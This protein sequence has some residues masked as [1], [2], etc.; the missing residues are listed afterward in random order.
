[1]GDRIQPGARVDREL[2]EEFKRWVKKSRG[3]R[4]GTVGQELEKAMRDRINGSG[5]ARQE[6]RLDRIEQKVE[7]VIESTTA[8]ADGGPTPARSDEP[9]THTETD[10][11][12]GAADDAP[13]EP[14]HPKASRAVKADYLAARLDDSNEVH[15]A[16]VLELVD[17]TYSFGDEATERLVAATFDRL[18]EDRKPHPRVDDLLIPPE[19]ADRFAE[20]IREDQS[21][22]ADARLDEL[23][24]ADPADTD[25]ADGDLAERVADVAEEDRELFDAL[26]EAEHER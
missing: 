15:R 6:E 3:D 17:E 2:Y 23:D 5:P 1:M 11:R 22:E 10:D 25:D 14:P 19:E 21:D 18:A 9:H 24:A 7:A 16:A 8:D 12:S 13:D 4:R 26:D 20:D